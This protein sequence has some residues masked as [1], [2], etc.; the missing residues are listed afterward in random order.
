MSLIGMGFM[1]VGLFFLLVAAIGMVRLP[2]VYTRSHAV[3]M[4]DS[5]GA[6]FLLTGLA[7]YQGFSGN[8]V[9]ILVVLVLI[10]LLNPVITHAT[11]RAA[12]RSGVKPWSK[13]K[14]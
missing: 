9:K 14:C 2:D 12:L 6:C 8:L 1:L 7:L 3:G 4:T 5:I 11:V 13:E 10:Y